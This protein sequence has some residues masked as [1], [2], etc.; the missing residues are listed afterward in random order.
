[1]EIS[2]NGIILIPLTETK[3]ETKNYEKR[4]RNGSGKIWNG[5]W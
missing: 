2:I 3:K 5:N 1:M 4:K